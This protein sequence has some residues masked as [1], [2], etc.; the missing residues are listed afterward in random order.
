MG[1]KEGGRWKSTLCRVQVGVM[2]GL[3]LLPCAAG[4]N[5]K[6]GLEGNSL[7]DACTQQAVLPKG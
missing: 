3:A 1:E 6:A 4:I 2:V 7:R 5:G